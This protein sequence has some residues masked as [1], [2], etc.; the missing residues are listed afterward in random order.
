MIVARAIQSMI[1]HCAGSQRDI[2]HFLKVYAYARTIGLLEGLSPDAQQRLELA[3]IV[4]D[5]ACPM[6]REKYG[7]TKPEYQ[8]PEGALM[9]RPFLTALGLPADVVDRLC[10]IVGHHHTQAYVD[11]PD[12]QILM[13]ADFLVNA[14]AHGLSE[15]QIRQTEARLFRTQAGIALLRS[16]YLHA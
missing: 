16:M 6:C 2:Q 15:D 13:E 10:Y 12:F 3:A 11:G 9:A 14:D 1:A 7:S 8:E 4:H 5:I